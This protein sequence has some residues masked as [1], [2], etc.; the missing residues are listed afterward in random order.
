MPMIMVYKAL[1][2]YYILSQIAAQKV[3]KTNGLYFYEIQRLCLSA[4][5]KQPHRLLF[6]YSVIK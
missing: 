4:A 6:M 3:S 2:V 5:L 1:Y